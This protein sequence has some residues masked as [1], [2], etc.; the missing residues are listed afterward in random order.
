MNAT[1]KAPSLGEFVD[2]A[3][4]GVDQPLAADPSEIVKTL[5]LGEFVDEATN[6]PGPQPQPLTLG[7]GRVIE[8]QIPDGN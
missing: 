6:S 3:L 2:D 4:E 8:D 5:F 7:S 1:V